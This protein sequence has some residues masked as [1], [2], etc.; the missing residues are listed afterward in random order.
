M[1]IVYI[2]LDE[3]PCNYMY[4]SQLA[5][6]TD[7]HL[8]VPGKQL[9]GNKKQPAPHKNLVTWLEKETVH[10]DYLIVSLDMLL[11]GGIVPS[12]LH[13]LQPD[14]VLTRLTILKGLKKKNPGM[15]IYANNLIMRSPAYNSDDEEPEYYAFYGEKLHLY[16]RLLDKLERSIVT[17]NT[18]QFNQLQKEIPVEV[19]SDYTERRK[20]NARAN[21]YALQ[22]V[23]EEIIDFLIIPLDDNAEYGY[24]AKEQRS[25]VESVLSLEI[26]EKVAIYPG[27]DEVGCTL[28]SRVF[29]TIHNYKP[30]IFTQYSSAKGPVIIP[31]LEDRPLGE[32]VTLQIAAAGGNITDRFMNAD[33]ILMIHS[34]AVSQDDIAEPVHKLSERDPSYFSEIHYQEFVT[35]ISS[36]LDQGKVVGVG[37]VALCNGSDVILMNLLRDNNLVDRLPCYAG[38]NTSGNTLGT[39][40]AH[41]IIEAFNRNYDPSK[42]LKQGREFY[43]TRLIEDWGY[44]AVV[45]HD[46]L[47]N[48]IERFGANYFDISLKLHDIEE[49]IKEKL[50]DFIQENLNTPELEHIKLE[51]VY[52]PWKRMFEVGLKIHYH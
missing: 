3:R 6:M 38:W 40:I 14:E 11:Y 41:L 30:T 34:P 27:A 47:Q 36:Y 44:Q 48:D 31:K 37:D 50:Q 45:K 18:D 16:G 17:K 52:S 49:L 28:F 33:G 5:A 39:I 32:S 46:I 1:K 51:Q 12:R 10:A 15:K 43:Y 2:P 20:I 8:M 24:S 26:S 22:L 23:K 19:L 29:C 13:H 7:L 25:L 42:F 9:V 21:H 35:L 4:P